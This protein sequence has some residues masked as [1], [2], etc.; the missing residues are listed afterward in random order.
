MVT[1][2]KDNM[3][4]L[5]PNPEPKNKWRRKMKGLTNKRKIKRLRI[6]SFKAYRNRIEKLANNLYF[7]ERLLQ[8]QAKKTWWGSPY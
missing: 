2:I 1:F 3:E 4:Y 5:L 6:L 7:R 8:A